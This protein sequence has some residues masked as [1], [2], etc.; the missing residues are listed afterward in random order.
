MEEVCWK[1]VVWAFWDG[2]VGGALLAAVS[3]LL[4]FY[5][6]TLAHIIAVVGLALGAVMIFLAVARA[7]ANTYFLSK[8]HVRRVYRL[9][10]VRVDEAPL[11][12]ITNVVVE[13][14]VL[15]RILG[16]G[17]VRCDTAGT[18]FAGVLFKGVKRPE[19]IA[20]AIRGRIEAARRQIGQANPASS[21]QG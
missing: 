11:D 2:I 7:A 6:F 17:D 15:G 5:R 4:L 3:A 16:F 8:S 20:E 10:V 13:Q 1:P 18:A 12:K 9:V 21:P 14:G 19:S